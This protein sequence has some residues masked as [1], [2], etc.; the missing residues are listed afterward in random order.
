MNAKHAKVGQFV[1]RGDYRRACKEGLSVA[2][3]TLDL[4][5]AFINKKQ[6]LCPNILHAAA[7]MWGIAS[8][9][10]CRWKAA[11]STDE[12]REKADMGQRLVKFQNQLNEV[13]TGTLSNHQDER[14]KQDFVAILQSMCEF[15][16]Q[17]RP[18]A[19]A[20]AQRFHSIAQEVDRQQQQAAQSVPRSSGYDY[21]RH[22][23]VGHH[24][25]H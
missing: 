3:D 17:M 21:R 13:L 6:Q 1:D 14:V 12:L 2:S 20:A 15:V 4:Y 10:H 11:G 23:G 24:H 7:N 8:L 16:G 25:G 22:Y 5:L 19:E 9:S 18:Y